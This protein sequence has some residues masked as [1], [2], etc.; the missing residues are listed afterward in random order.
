MTKEA[1]L[2]WIKKKKKHCSSIY[3]TWQA[4]YWEGRSDVLECLERMIKGEEDEQ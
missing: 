3:E 2:D 1:I 4:P